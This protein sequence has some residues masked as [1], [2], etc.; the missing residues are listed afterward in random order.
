MDDQVIF[1]PVFPS[2]VPFI[3]FL[4]SGTAVHALFYISLALYGA[5]SAVLLYH[6]LRYNVGIF[7]T[8]IVI[9]A[10]A[11]GSF[12]LLAASYSASLLF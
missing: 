5:V 11:A 3:S 1:Q 7:R 4:F 9:A 8:A 12:V 6:W 2:A 10:Y